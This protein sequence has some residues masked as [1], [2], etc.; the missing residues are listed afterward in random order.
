MFPM[1]ESELVAID[2]AARAFRDAWGRVESP[3][4]AAKFDFTRRDVE[5]IDYMDYE[6]LP[7]PACGTDGAVLIVAEVVRRA[8]GVAWFMSFR[9]DW[10]LAERG[11]FTSVAVAPRARFHEYYCGRGTQDG[12]YL[13]LMAELALECVGAQRG[14]GV[15]ALFPEGNEYFERL[16]KRLDRM[17]K[18]RGRTL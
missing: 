5:A 12:N 17:G 18:G 13:N 4:F 2:R 7:F 9:G 8:A 15:L 3:P 10:V 14:D 16:R 11:D 6:G 1:P